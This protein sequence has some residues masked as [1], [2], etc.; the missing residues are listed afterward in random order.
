MTGKQVWVIVTVVGAGLMALLLLPCRRRLRTYRF[1]VRY[2]DGTYPEIVK[3]KDVS[4]GV[5]K[6]ARM[7]D[8]ETDEVL[9]IIEDRVEIWN[10]KKKR[11]EKARPWWEEEKEP[12]EWEK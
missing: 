11:W 9:A 5:D 4:A 10:P 7:L 1:F 3:A 2:L 8:M 6:L 12:Y